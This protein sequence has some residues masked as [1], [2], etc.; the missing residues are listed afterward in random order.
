MTNVAIVK[1]YEEDNLPVEDIALAYGLTKEQV[2]LALAQGS[3]KFRAAV[4]KDP[5]L[6]SDSTFNIAAQ[7]MEQALYAEHPDGTIDYNTRV[8]AAKFIINEHKGRHDIKAVQGL[9]INVS[10]FNVQLKNAMEALVKGK[11]KVIDIPAEAKQLIESA[12]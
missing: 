10:N 7:T 9:N 4:K 8:R 5:T 6:F 11:Q 3:V 1:L 2:E 12:A